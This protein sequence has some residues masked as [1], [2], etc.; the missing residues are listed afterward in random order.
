MLSFILRESKCPRR[1]PNKTQIK[2]LL[3][4]KRK[5]FTAEFIPVKRFNF[6]HS[7]FPGKFLFSYNTVIVYIGCDQC[8]PPE[9]LKQNM[10]QK[11]LR[12]KR[13]AFTAEFIPV[14]RFNFAHSNFPG[15]F[16]LSYDTVIICTGCYQCSPPEQLEQNTNQKTASIQKNSSYCWVYSSKKI[17]LCS[18]QL[19][20]KIPYVL[21]HSNRIYWMLSVQP[22]WTTKAK[23]IKKLLRFKRTPLTADFIP[24]KRFNF[25]HSNFPG[26]F[27]LFYNTVIVYTGCYQCGPPEQL[28][29]NTNQK[30]ALIQKNTSYCWLYS[31]KKIQLSSFQLSWKIPFVLQHSN[32]IYWM[33]SVRPPWT[34]KTK[35][36]SKNCS[37]SKEQLLLLSLF[38]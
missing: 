9:Q 19:S 35:H 7:N 38:Q 12:F 8:S 22:P 34:T 28:K 5:A 11:L 33:L 17:W 18:F 14:K 21:Q 23:H 4:F 26:K 29:Q 25:A 13:T 15:K 6:A 27:L 10:N 31:S 24:A 1:Q 37:H 2:K 3:R 36:K 32:H 30:T 20:W 16:L